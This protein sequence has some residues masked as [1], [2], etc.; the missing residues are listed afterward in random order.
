MTYIKVKEITQKKDENPTIY[1]NQ[2]STAFRKYTNID[3]KSDEGQT[4]L[5][6]HSITQA[7]LD[8]QR[9]LQMWKPDPKPHKLPSCQRSLRRSVT[10]TGQRKKRKES[11]KKGAKFS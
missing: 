4:F 10:R 7:V 6:M 3:P 1:L 2:L 5:T 8:I 9:K 11:R